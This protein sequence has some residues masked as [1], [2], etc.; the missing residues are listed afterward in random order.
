MRLFSVWTLTSAVFG[1]ATFI[2]AQER[3]V[4]VTG[5]RTHAGNTLLLFPH[6]QKQPT[7]G[8]PVKQRWFLPNVA[9]AGFPRM[10]PISSNS[11]FVALN[12]PRESTV[13]H[14]TKVGKSNHWQIVVT[15]LP[16]NTRDIL[17]L[18]DGYAAVTR[19]EV[20]LGQHESP[21]FEALT[22]FPLKDFQRIFKVPGGSLLVG[23]WGIRYISSRT[24]RICVHYQLDSLEN[25]SSNASG[26]LLLLTG[27]RIVTS[28]L[29]ASIEIE[30]KS[31]EKGSTSRTFVGTNLSRRVLITLRRLANGGYAKEESVSEA[32][33]QPGP[34]YVQSRVQWYRWTSRKLERSRDHGKTW[35]SMIDADRDGGGSLI[36]LSMTPFGPLIWD[37]DGY[38]SLHREVQGTWD[39]FRLMLDEDSE[40]QPLTASYHNR[41]VW[42]VARSGAFYE[43]PILMK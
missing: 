29:G 41:V 31:Q 11:F 19:D 35:L 21:L 13:Y 3:T 17:H 16:G 2:T 8:K 40:D 43:V 32:S 5:V 9:N 7:F 23:R 18:T 26:G 39:S 10:W 38:F 14:C 22:M 30:E 4:Q 36:G 33:G 15:D 27:S 12:P 20:F 34:T 42:A 24:E 37:R 28:E 6:K 25:V 1:L